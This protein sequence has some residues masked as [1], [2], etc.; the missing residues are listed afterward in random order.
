[1]GFRGSWLCG[2]IVV[3]A[4][5]HYAKRAFTWARK[6]LVA[7]AAAAVALA[8]QAETMKLP[9]EQLTSPRSWSC[10]ASPTSGRSR[11]PVPERWKLKR[12]VVH[13]RYTVSANL[14]PETSTLVVKVRNE[15]IAQARLNPQ[16]PEVKLGVEIPTIFLEP[17][18]NP[19][20]FAVSQHATKNQCESP[21]T[22]DLWTNISLRES[23]VEME[24]DLRRPA[25]RALGAVRR[26]SSTRAHAGGRGPHRGART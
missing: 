20:V 5:W 3:K 12:A 15:P 22:P 11:C 18:Y 10:A 26:T 9:F 17:G 24:Y 21:C 6:G 8:S 2:A 1:M 7:L 4:S 14:I 16:A 23:Y 25:A 13:L 19:I